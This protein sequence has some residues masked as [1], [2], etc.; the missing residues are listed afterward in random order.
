[1]VVICFLKGS[2]S[3]LVKMDFPMYDLSIL[4]QSDAISLKS[5]MVPS[6]VV[7]ITAWF[8]GKKREGVCNALEYCSV[9]AS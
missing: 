3:R 5:N 1:M 2:S 7:V 4:K 9:Y 8:C 6:T